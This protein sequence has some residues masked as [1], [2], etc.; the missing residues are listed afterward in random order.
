VFV[1][2]SVHLSVCLPFSLLTHYAPLS[3]IFLLFLKTRHFSL[4]MLTLRLI[5][6]SFLPTLLPHSRTLTH[7]PLSLTYISHSPSFP[8]SYT[9]SISR[10]LPP[11]PLSPFSLSR[12]YP[13]SL[14]LS[15]SHK[16]TRTHSH[17]LYLTYTHTLSR[18]QSLYLTL[19]HKQHKQQKQLFS[20]FFFVVYAW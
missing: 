1:T 7:L 13:L 18:N 16:L 17:Y 12:R 3:H 6:L 14:S 5:N 20:L 10:T 9:P 15:C 19:T 11:L 2:S 4:S 8:H